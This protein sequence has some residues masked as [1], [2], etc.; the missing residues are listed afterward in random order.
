MQPVRSVIVLGGGTAGFL[1]AI[2]L[3][4]K[5]PD[6]PVRLIR[7]SAI[8]IIGVGEGTTVAVPKILHDF[9]G[10]DVAEFYREAQPIWKL[11]IKYIWGERDVFYFT[12]GKQM[13]QAMPNLERP[14]GY[15]CHDSVDCA[16][17]DTALMQY[18]RAFVRDPNT[19]YPFVSRCHA[20]HLENKIFVA[21]L[22]RLAAA[23][24][25]TII[26]DTVTQVDVDDNGVTALHLQSGRT[27]TADLY[28][29]ASG[30]LSELLGKALNEPFVSYTP[31][32]FCDRACVGGWKREPGEVIQP[33]TVAET[34]NAGWCWRIDHE[35]LINR[36]YVYSSSFISDEEAER[37][38]RAK[39]PKVQQTRV[40]RF[41]SGRH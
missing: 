12:F 13:T 34:M 14:I 20:Y 26:D 10:I 25:T 27:E 4:V 15:Y 3:R 6:I 29:D 30:F 23:R 1:A 22:E 16:S 19:G 9:L 36:G 2:A 24:G 17:V 11:G 40:V 18:D 28:V 41:R 38:F 37:E 33:Y 39:N 31:S 8:G 7:S 5:H 35:H 32:L 21:Y